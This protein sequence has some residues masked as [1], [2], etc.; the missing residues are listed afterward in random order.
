MQR[1]RL[2]DILIRMG[3]IDSMQLASA[4]AHQRQWGTPLGQTLVE[5][6]FLTPDRLLSALS[7][8]SG[9]PVVDLDQEYLD[10]SVAP[11]LPRKAAERCRAVPMR[12]EGKRDEVLV[13][14]IAAPALLSTIDALQKASGKHRIRA[15]LA[16]DGAI[17]RAI[18]RIYDGNSLGRASV[19][20]AAPLQE[21]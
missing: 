2:G 8:Q 10:G 20:A 19:D 11:L 1:P 3:A 7:E 4:L 21:A 18:A 15:L 13:V 14:A 6:R 9:L 17:D 16:Y 5:K 12:T